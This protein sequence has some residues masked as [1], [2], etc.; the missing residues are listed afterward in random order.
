MPTVACGG[1]VCQL[2]GGLPGALV[3]LAAVEESTAP[4]SCCI[5]GGLSVKL[6][7][8][9]A[10]SIAAVR[11]PLA[12]PKCAKV[13]SPPTDPGDS[14]LAR[15]DDRP[16]DRIE[17]SLK[18]GE[19][20]CAAPA[21]GDGGRADGTT[22]GGGVWVPDLPGRASAPRFGD[23]AR[24]GDGARFGDNVGAASLIP[25]HVSSIPRGLGP[26]RGLEGRRLAGGTGGGVR[27]SDLRGAASLPT[28]VA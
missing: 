10:A 13:A 2:Q 11:W 16:S 19:T 18:D 9:D 4:D 15:G 12:R 17:D 28:D 3:P 20:A 25:L 24:L 6:G 22:E 8:V 7:R 5:D 27:L 26:P 23:G 21:L 14:P 1:Q